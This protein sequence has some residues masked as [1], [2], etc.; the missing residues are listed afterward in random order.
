MRKKDLIVIVPV[1]VV[2]LGL[3]GFLQ[4]GSTPYAALLSSLNLLK[5]CL[6]PL[7]V[8]FFIEAARWQAGKIP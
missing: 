7:P 5:V 8:N 3:I 2:V 1:A 4:E 6:D